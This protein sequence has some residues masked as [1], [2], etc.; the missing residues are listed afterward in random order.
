MPSSFNGPILPP[1]IFPFSALCDLIDRNANV[2]DAEVIK[3]HTYVDS[4]AKVQHRCLV[5]EVCGGEGDHVWLRLDRRPTSTAALARGL[6]T[7]ANDQVR[8]DTQL[9][10]H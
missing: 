9:F 5:V 4:K 2:S 10:V 3:V 7:L 1:Y 8:S 6:K